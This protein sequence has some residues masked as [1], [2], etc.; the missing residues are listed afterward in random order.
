[1]FGKTDDVKRYP[2]AFLVVHEQFF[3]EFHILNG[4]FIFIPAASFHGRSIKF[5]DVG[6]LFLAGKYQLDPGVV[7]VYMFIDLFDFRF[8]VFR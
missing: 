3:V 5:D 2:L 8:I 6:K 1:M 7:A 4:P